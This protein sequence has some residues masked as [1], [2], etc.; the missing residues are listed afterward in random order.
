MNP[1]EKRDYDRKLQELEQE[2]DRNQRQPVGE[3]QPGQPIQR[4]AN[5]PQADGLPLQQIFNWFN[6]L[7][8]AGKVAVALVAALVAF[9]VLKSVFQLVTSI[10]SLAVL[11][12]ILYLV[13]RFFVARQSP[14]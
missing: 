9:S 1:Q 14:K 11:G 7:P 10:I 4:P 5:P 3:T 12:V 8:D 13:Y 2:L 6:R